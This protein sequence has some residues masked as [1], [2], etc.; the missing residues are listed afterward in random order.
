[1]EQ[2]ADIDT[3]DE[4]PELPRR[5]RRRVERHEPIRQQ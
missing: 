4:R 1:M 3:R 5:Q 2:V